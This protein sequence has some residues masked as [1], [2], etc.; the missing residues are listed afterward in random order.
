MSDTPK[1]PR[2]IHMAMLEAGY[3]F[4]IVLQVVP[5]GNVPLKTGA[6]EKAQARL[7]ELDGDG[8][9]TRY[10]AYRVTTLA[11]IDTFMPELN[12][13]NYKNMAK[14]PEKESTDSD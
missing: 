14:L 1:T 5:N 2:E 7:D 3:D 4:E 8:K 11:Q 12:P 9:M 10:A 6:L 13:E